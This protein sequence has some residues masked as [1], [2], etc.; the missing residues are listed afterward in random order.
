MWLCCICLQIIANFDLALRLVKLMTLKEHMSGEAPNFTNHAGHETQMMRET[1]PKILNTIINIFKFQERTSLSLIN[2]VHKSRDLNARKLN[3]QDLHQVLGS[4]HPWSIQ[5]KT[6]GRSYVSNIGD[7]RAEISTGHIAV[8][9]KNGHNSLNWNAFWANKDFGRRFRAPCIGSIGWCNSQSGQRG[10]YVKRK[11]ATK[12]NKE[13]GD[14]DVR[15]DWTNFPL[16]VID[17]V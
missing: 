14:D 15:D 1:V 17:H 8:T 13:G 4:T 10:K 12:D 3:I 16:S 9:G 7:A 5:L 6:H 11:V 2:F